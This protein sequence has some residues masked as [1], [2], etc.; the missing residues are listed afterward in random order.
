[1]QRYRCAQCGKTFSDRKEYGS[2]GDTWKPAN[3]GHLKTGQ[4]TIGRTDPVILRRSL[5]GNLFS[6]APSMG[7]IY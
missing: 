2:S 5:S 6:T 4:R 1:M 3:E 7:P